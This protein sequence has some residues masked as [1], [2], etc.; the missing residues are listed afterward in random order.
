MLDNAADLS[1]ALVAPDARWFRDQNGDLWKVEIRGASGRGAPMGG[2]LVFTAG[3]GGVRARLKRERLEGIGS[4][5]D[6]DLVKLL[7]EARRSPA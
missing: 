6:A 3:K 5:P 4:L 7:Y 1:S 2:W